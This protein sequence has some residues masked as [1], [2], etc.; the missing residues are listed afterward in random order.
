MLRRVHSAASAIYGGYV[1]DKTLEY[2]QMCRKSQEIQKLWEPSNGD[3]FHEM[4][5]DKPPIW[6]IYTWVGGHTNKKTPHKRVWI[7]RQDQLQDMVIDTY[8]QQWQDS[9]MLGLMEEVVSWGKQLPYAS[10]EQCWLCF[11]MH[12]KY[13]KVWTGA[14]W[15]SE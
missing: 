8:R 1:M 4:T 7:P 3:F 15:V 12:V 11:V 14:E 9:V 2:V 13:S 10:M 6:G 5:D